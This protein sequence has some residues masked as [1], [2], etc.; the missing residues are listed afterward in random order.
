MHHSM[1]MK[2]SCQMMSDR[3]HRMMSGQAMSPVEEIACGYCQ[4]LIHLPFVLN[5]VTALLWLMLLYVQRSPV[6][7]AVFL[8]VIRIW[9][10]QC[11][12]APPVF[13]A[14]I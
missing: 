6:L 12:R 5:V 11:A 14:A 4:L 2:D 8:P 1:V 13:S 7:Y 10:P 3:D 9:A